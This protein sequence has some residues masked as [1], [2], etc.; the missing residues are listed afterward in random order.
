MSFASVGMLLFIV[1]AA[2]DSV[3]RR[4]GPLAQANAFL[5]TGGIRGRPVTAFSMA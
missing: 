4:R 3:R 2:V 5:S 1:L